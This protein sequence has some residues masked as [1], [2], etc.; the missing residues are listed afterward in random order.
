MAGRSRLTLLA[1]EPIDPPAATP[2]QP[3]VAPPTSEKAAID[4]W[5]LV[6]LGLRVLSTRA[7]AAG[8]HLLT[9][10]LAGMGFALWRSVLPNPSV[11][12]LAG[13]GL[14]GAFALLILLIRRA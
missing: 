7:V 5:A 10:I 1:E 8:S 11:E 12:Q 3:A 2:A 13:L 6:G 4:A 14:Y 9:L